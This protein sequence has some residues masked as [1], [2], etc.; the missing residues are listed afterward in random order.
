MDLQ[1]VTPWHM[2]GSQADGAVRLTGVDV[3]QASSQLARVNYKRPDT[4]SFC[5]VLNLLT[6]TDVLTPAGAVQIFAHFDLTLGVGRSSNTLR[7]F[8]VL[9]I[10]RTFPFL[11]PSLMPAQVFTTVGGA[12]EDIDGTIARTPNGSVDFPSSDVQCE[13]RILVTGS[14]TLSITYSVSAYFAPRTHVRPE[15]LGT[16]T[17]TKQA[18]NGIPRFNGGEDKGT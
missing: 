4:W 6:F 17:G 16:A 9:K 18:G 11:T 12:F 8:A 7:D 2:W 13:A 5:F 10:G 14:T 1:G 3:Q 15:W